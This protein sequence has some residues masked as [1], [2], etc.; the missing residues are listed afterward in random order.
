[1]ALTYRWRVRCI[2]DTKNEYTTSATKPTVC[3]VDG[4]HTI[5]AALTTRLG[6]PDKIIIPS[7]SAG[8]II[9]CDA[10]DSTKQA[11]IDC[12]GIG[13]GQTRKITVPDKDVLLSV[14]GSEYG[15]AESLALSTTTSP[16]Y[17]QK[18]LLTTPSLPAGDYHI[19][20]SYESGNDSAEAATVTR[21]RVD[22]T[23]LSEPSSKIGNNADPS[24]WQYGGFTKATLTAAV[25][26]IDIYHKRDA[27]TA[28][29]KNARLTIWRIS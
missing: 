5:N 25:H 6:R 18:L 12:A 3:P 10:A 7:D 22:S 19:Q 9:I 29:I 23:I 4:G 13:S 16:T 2:T 11:H 26:T 17:Q 21:V 28:R 1:M 14:F 20:W 27:G 8:K 24:D 15:Y